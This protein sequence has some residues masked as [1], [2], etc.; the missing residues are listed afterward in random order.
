MHTAAGQYVVA[1]LWPA[2]PCRRQAHQ[3]KVRRAA[4]NVHHQ[5]QLLARD[6]G[7]IGKR[8]RDRLVLERHLLKAHGPRNPGQGVL[9]L[10]IGLGI[11]VDKKDRTADYR[12]AEVA[13]G[14]VLGPALEFANE[15][16]QQ[17]AK[18]H[19]PASNFGLLVDQRRAEQA[20]HRAH[21]ATFVACQVIGQRGT[22]ITDVGIFGVK[23]HH[24]GQGQFV[25]LQR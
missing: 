9:G 17:R 12:A 5:H 1:P 7:L 25:A 23:K 6:L 21:Q 3:R 13:A 8:G 10:P 15:L 19:R 24:R 4:T 16:R 2:R 11:P 18:R 20:F 14:R 22:T